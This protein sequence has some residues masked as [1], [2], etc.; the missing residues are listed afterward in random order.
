MKVSSGSNKMKVEDENNLETHGE[1][2][3]S[4]CCAKASPV[5]HQ[6]KDTKIE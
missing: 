4:T 5:L 3:T 6:I 2:T 1:T